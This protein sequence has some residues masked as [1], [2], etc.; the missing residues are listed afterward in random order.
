MLI[1]KDIRVEYSE[2]KG[3]P[4]VMIRQFYEEDGEWKP[5]KS[6]INLKYNDWLEFV[7]NFEAIKIEIDSKT[8]IK[9]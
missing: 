1:G 3:K 7:E 4:Y 8:L 5:G 2:Y 9:P 6:G